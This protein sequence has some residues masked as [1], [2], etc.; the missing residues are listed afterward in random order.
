MTVQVSK[1]PLGQRPRIAVVGSINMDLVFRSPRMPAI[2]ETV[3]GTEFFQLPGGKGANQAVAAARQGAEV[4]FVGAVGADL[5][6][7]QAL[8]GLAEEG[9]VTDQVISS[10]AAATGVAG[11]FVDDDGANSIVIA[12]GAN[13]LLTVAQ[14]E[15]AEAVIAHSA[16]LVCQLESPLDSVHRAIGIARA[17]GVQVVFNP[18]P[19]HP[20]D[21]AMLA[22]VDY[23]VVNETEAAQLSGVTVDD[24]DSAVKA[25]EALRARGAA[26][27]LLT[28][29]EQGV[30]V[31]GVDGF[32]FI[33]AVKVE[34]IDTTAAGD[35]FVGAFTVAMARGFALDA[36]VTEAQ[37]AAALT[38]TRLGAQSAIPTRDEVIHLMTER[39]GQP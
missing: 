18:A 31:A 23:L 22:Q 37:Y 38:V 8:S 20:I 3:K 39:R 27:V 26:V 12:P 11:I 30:L 15:A 32:R 29:G 9:I 25:A 21:D 4:H 33:P 6:G 16:F 24:A 14:V 13:E 17:Q 36:A 10:S 19:A 5:F 2:G 35:T 28:M 34:A 7:E 1:Y